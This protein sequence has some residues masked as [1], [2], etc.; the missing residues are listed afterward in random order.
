MRPHGDWP[1]VLSPTKGRQKRKMSEAE[2][3]HTRIA[4]ISAASLFLIVPF[5]IFSLSIASRSWCD[6]N[7]SA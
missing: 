5:V 3:V 6:H 2:S 7:K 1:K 4:C